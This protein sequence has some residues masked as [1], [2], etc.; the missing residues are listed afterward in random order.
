MQALQLVHG[1]SGTDAVKKGGKHWR[2]VFTA[3]GSW[4]S[5]VMGDFPTLLNN[6]V[7]CSKN[8]RATKDLEWVK[9]RYP[10]L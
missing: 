9:K 1:S 7:K 4:E 2:R 3:H 6:F 10:G 8:R 5:K